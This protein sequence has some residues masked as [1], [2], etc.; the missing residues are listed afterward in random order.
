MGMREDQFVFIN[1]AVR[2]EVGY[3]NAKLVCTDND[4][5]DDGDDDDD[6]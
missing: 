4:D 2:V 5:D 1:S 3:S 6:D